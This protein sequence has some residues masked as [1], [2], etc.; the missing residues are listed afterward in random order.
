MDWFIICLIGLLVI[1]TLI[2]QNMQL[3]MK[4]DYLVKKADSITRQNDVL[5]IQL[6]VA[7]RD[8]C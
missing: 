3:R 4:N 5:K 7:M 6:K 1:V 8:D 2:P